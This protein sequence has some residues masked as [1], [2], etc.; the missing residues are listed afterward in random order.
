M[1]CPSSIQL[2]LFLD[3]R[4]VVLANEVVTAL[5]ARDAARAQERLDEMK[6]DAHD[7]PGLPALSTLVSALAQW[8]MPAREPAQIAL[9]VAQLES[10]FGP[11]AEAGL[12]LEAP[13]FLAPFFRELAA[14]A[15]GL[16]Y[17]RGNPTAYRAALC[18]RCG[19]FSDAEQAALAVANWSETPDALHWLTLAR[20]RLHGVDAA[21]ASLFAL[22]WREPNRLATVL[23]ELSD[24]LLDRQWLAFERACDWDDIR[25]ADLPSWFP[26]WYL[27]EHPAAGKDL[28]D[29]S[30]PDAAPAQAARLLVRLFDME[31]QGNSRTLVGLRACLRDLNPG[32]FSLYMARRAV[33][34]R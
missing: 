23:T 24:E 6:R 34:H 1:V 4:A 33:Q 27:V 30:F 20:Y 22:A 3:S 29:A 16:S 15:D 32:L 7:H 17:D 10:E 28:A 8:R 14:A 12:G 18:L 25:E 9:L 31:R 11:A 19:D 21:R 2:D 5:L 26:A 13:L